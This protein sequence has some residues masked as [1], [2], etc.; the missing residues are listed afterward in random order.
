[1]FL[2]LPILEAFTSFVG[3]QSFLSNA[4]AKLAWEGDTIQGNQSVKVL[5]PSLKP[6]WHLKMDGWNTPFGMAYFQVRT[7]S[8]RECRSSHKKSQ[9]DLYQ[10]QGKLCC[11]YLTIL[12]YVKQSTGWDSPFLPKDAFR[13]CNL[14]QNTPR[15]A[16]HH[17]QFPRVHWFAGFDQMRINISPLDCC[18][19]CVV[20]LYHPVWGWKKHIKQQPSA[21]EW[22]L[23]IYQKYIY[24][25]YTN[26]KHLINHA[27]PNIL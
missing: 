24:T 5:I 20:F 3:T 27:Y 9:S 17:K 18:V 22:A 25:L 8:F 19:F 1:M 7:V 12:L 23:I 15:N 6:T 10:K 4:V 11:T 2:L 14:K 21:S 13:R 16:K 26:E